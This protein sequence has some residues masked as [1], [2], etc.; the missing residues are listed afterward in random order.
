MVMDN[1]VLCQQISP[2]RDAAAFKCWVFTQT[3]QGS[4]VGI[5]TELASSSNFGI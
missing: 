1:L 4:L 2:E 3:T 5:V